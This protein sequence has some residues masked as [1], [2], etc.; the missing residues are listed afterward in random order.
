MKLKFIKAE[1]T[2]HNAKATVH[3]SGKLGFSKD[4]IDFLGIKE[5]KSIQFAQNEDDSADLNLYA[6]V[7]SGMQEGAFR[8]SKAGEYFYVNTKNLFD[9]LGVDYKS[10]KFIYDLV[11]E[12]Y[13][14]MQIIKMLRREIK[15]RSKGTPVQ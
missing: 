7:N 15:K 2:E 11:K 4:A 9:A 12:Q 14:G 6:V 1:D 3:T 5:G 8:I 13:E 10:K